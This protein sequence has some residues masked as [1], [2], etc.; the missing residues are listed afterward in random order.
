MSKLS[1]RHR[2]LVKLG[3]REDSPNEDYGEFMPQSGGTEMEFKIDERNDPRYGGS[4]AKQLESRGILTLEDAAPV[5]IDIIP[6]ITRYRW[7]PPGSSLWPQHGK[8]IFYGDDKKEYVITIEQG[9]MGLTYTADKKDFEESHGTESL[10][11]NKRIQRPCGKS[12]KSNPAV[13]NGCDWGYDICRDHMGKCVKRTYIPVGTKFGWNYDIKSW[14]Y[15]VVGLFGRT[16]YYRK[17]W[18]ARSG[19]RSEALRTD[20]RSSIIDRLT[21]LVAG[22]QREAQRGGQGNLKLP[23]PHSIGRLPNIVSYQWIPPK[24]KNSLGMF[25]F[26]D[27]LGKKYNIE[28]QHDDIGSA[29]HLRAAGHYNASTQ[30]GKTTLDLSD[31]PK[32]SAFGWNYNLNSWV[33]KIKGTKEQYVSKPLRGVENYGSPMAGCWNR[34]YLVDRLIKLVQKPS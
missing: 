9:D 24:R 6:S 29:T 3:E 34:N 33:Y 11:S 7:V 15:K 18:L 25:V 30:D 13:S 23:Q 5:T 17:P 22:E 10:V 2:Q 16:K 19:S 26:Y 27:M 4:K 20:G 31:I 1:E 8:F 21:K 14:V 12:G 32:G 28:L